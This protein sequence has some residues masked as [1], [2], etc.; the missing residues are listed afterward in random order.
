M[1]EGDLCDF[2]VDGERPENEVVTQE[3]GFDHPA[4][5][6]TEGKYVHV[7]PDTLQCHLF[8]KR[9][10]PS[11]EKVEISLNI[12]TSLETEKKSIMQ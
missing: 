3:N 10:H 2:P 8:G 12:I 11:I 4:K 1:R 7:T 5:E 9:R 6:V